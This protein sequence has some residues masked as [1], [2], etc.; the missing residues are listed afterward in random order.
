MC[1]QDHHRTYVRKNPRVR[2]RRR[3]RFANDV[4]ESESDDDINKKSFN[5]KQTKRQPKKYKPNIELKK[6]VEEFNS[7]CQ[8][9]D[10]YDLVIEK[11]KEE[12]LLN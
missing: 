2:N 10:E 4:S 7:M 1:L 11:E 3:V 12:A 8:E 5:Q 6:F 9:V